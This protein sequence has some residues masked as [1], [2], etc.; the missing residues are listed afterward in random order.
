MELPQPTAEKIAL[1]KVPGVFFGR[2][3]SEEERV[4]LSEVGR[5]LY[6]ENVEVQKD[7]VADGK[8]WLAI[9]DG[10]VQVK[11]QERKN[12]LEIPMTVLGHSLTEG[13]REDLKAGKVVAVEF[14]GTSYFLQVDRELNRVVVSTARELGVP[15]ELG[16]YRLTR[17]DQERFANRAP[18]PLRVYEN[19]RTGT[20]FLAVVRPTADG[21]GLEFSHYKVVEQKDVARMKERYNSGIAV[22]DVVQADG[23][24][25]E[26][27]AAM[28]TKPREHGMGR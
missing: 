16:G 26:R 2:K 14:R 11:F 7:R 22:A 10:E 20:H 8:I 5:T 23:R 25:R 12:T 4:R 18:L 1:E 27:P 24:W 9:Q 19:R 17:E 28:Q 21:K 13:E 3:L 6:V 15:R